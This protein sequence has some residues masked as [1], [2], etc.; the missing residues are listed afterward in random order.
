MRRKIFL[1]VTS[2]LLSSCFYYQ[3]AEKMLVMGLV[4]GKN[5]EDYD[6]LYIFNGDTT[7]I[8]K[9]EYYNSEIRWN[10]NGYLKAFTDG[11]CNVYMKQSFF[12]CGRPLRDVISVDVYLKNN[13]TGKIFCVGE[14]KIDMNAFPSTILVTQIFVG[15]RIDSYRERKKYNIDWTKVQPVYS[16]DIGDT[17]YYYTAKY[18]GDAGDLNY[19]IDDKNFT[20]VP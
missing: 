1:L 12:N 7:V 2:A 5:V 15:S 10:K 3:S 20:E 11:F 17:I 8:S 4:D 19:Y 6:L 9:V 18:K 16:N 14:K 13:K